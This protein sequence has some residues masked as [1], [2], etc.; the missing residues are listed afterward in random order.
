MILATDDAGVS[1]IDLSHEFLLAARTYGLGYRSLKAL[2]RNSLG[3]SFLP[4][5]SL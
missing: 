5:D 1:R 4:G 2:A 3:H